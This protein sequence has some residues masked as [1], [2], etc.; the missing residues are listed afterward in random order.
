MQGCRIARCGDWGDC[1]EFGEDGNGG[2]GRGGLFRVG[3]ESA[4]SIRRAWET[5]G[6]LGMPR[7]ERGA[8]ARVGG[9]G[10]RKAR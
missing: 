1:D 6:G 3:V 8:L 4:E 2:L 5:G 10:G 9:V 7:S